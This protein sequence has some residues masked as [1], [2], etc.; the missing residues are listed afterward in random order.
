MQQV[1]L[2]KGVETEIRELEREINGWLQE[3]EGIT[4]LHAFGNMS[5]QTQSPGT[6]KMGSKF[7]SS[8]VFLA[9]LYEKS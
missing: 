1:R 3:N 5:P 9:I 7:D 4:I 8:D 6:T 2:F